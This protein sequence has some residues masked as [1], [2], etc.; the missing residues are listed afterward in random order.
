MAN[1]LSFSAPSV[2]PEEQ[3]SSSGDKKKRLPKS[4]RQIKIK[5]KWIFRIK[6]VGTREGAEEEEDTTYC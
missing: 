5:I 4:L 1:R 6:M 2:L 3:K